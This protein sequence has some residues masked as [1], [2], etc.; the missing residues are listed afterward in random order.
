MRTRSP[1]A[2]HPFVLLVVGD[3][4]VRISVSG[5]GDDDADETPREGPEETEDPTAVPVTDPS[6]G[7]LPFTGLATSLLF[8][9]AIVAIAVSRVLR[10]A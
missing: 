3:V 8:V 9:M 7:D 6:E 5:T 10:R 4:E 1:G 2:D